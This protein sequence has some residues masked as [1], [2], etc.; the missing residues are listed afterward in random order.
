MN[1][2]TVVNMRFRAVFT[3]VLFAFMFYNLP[4]QYVMMSHGKQVIVGRQMYTDLVV[5][6]YCNKVQV[7]KI[8][9]Q[10]FHICY[11]R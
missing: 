9:H 4:N 8:G 3:S 1:V 11:V 6:N 7:K 2:R 5:G 10:I